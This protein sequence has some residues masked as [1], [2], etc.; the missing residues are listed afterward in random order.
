MLLFS[1]KNLKWVQSQNITNKSNK[2]NQEKNAM[3]V[4][5]HN[6]V[7]AFRFWKRCFTKS[8]SRVLFVKKVLGDINAINCLGI[9]FTVLIVIAT[10]IDLGLYRLWYSKSRWLVCGGC[11]TKLWETYWNI[12]MNTRIINYIANI[13]LNIGDSND[14][15]T[16]LNTSQ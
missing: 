14:W 8:V 10:R 6:L 2:T 1:T 7:L 5:K 16:S 15:Q 13:F 3:N 9:S 11:G 4:A 12:E